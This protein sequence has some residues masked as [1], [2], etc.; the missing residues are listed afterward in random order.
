M[1]RSAA[2]K[3]QTGRSLTAALGIIVCVAACVRAEIR[4]EPSADDGRP[5]KYVVML[6]GWNYLVASANGTRRLGFLTT[7]HVEARNGDAAGERAIREVLTDPDFRA[8]MRNTPADPPRIE[9]QR[10][11]EVD[12]FASDSSPG[13][14]Y[15]FFEDRN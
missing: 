4:P 13:L 2:E 14:G 12:S 5:K 8:P 11:I 7:R 9:V 3:R 10:H 1:R 15:I 6:E